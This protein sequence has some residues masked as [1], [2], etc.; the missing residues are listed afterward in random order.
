MALLTSVMISRMRDGLGSVGSCLLLSVDVARAD[1][2][3]KLRHGEWLGLQLLQLLQ[4]EVIVAGWRD[5][6]SRRW[7]SVDGRRFGFLGLGG[8][9]GRNGGGGD[10][11]GLCGHALKH[12]AR[13]VVRLAGSRSLL[14]GLGWGEEA[15]SRASRQVGHRSSGSAQ[16]GEARRVWHRRARDERA[17]QRGALH[18]RRQHVTE[19]EGRRRHE[20]LGYA[21]AVQ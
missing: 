7:V 19:G 8:R 13:A 15:A 12:G 6:G 17:L 18:V 5:G 14:Q 21:G 2:S 3:S 11:G 9:R 4:L 20:R 16:I 1:L 10:R